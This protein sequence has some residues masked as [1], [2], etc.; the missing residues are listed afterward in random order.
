MQH[1]RRNATF[2]PIHTL[3]H[4]IANF[5]ILHLSSFALTGSNAIS[6]PRPT[7]V[8]E[9]E[10]GCGE[11]SAKHNDFDQPGKTSKI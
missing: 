10:L 11:A 6:K 3:T 7:Y 1:N 2:L 9:P 8:D 5:H 4:I